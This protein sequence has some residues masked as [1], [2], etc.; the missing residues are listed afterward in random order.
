MRFN[1]FMWRVCI[2]VEHNGLVG[3]ADQGEL[4]E[5]VKRVDVEAVEAGEEDTQ[6]EKAGDETRQ[7]EGL[8]VADEL[9]L[10]HAERLD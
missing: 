5:K 8:L 3:D 4:P 6:L 7:Q 9:E 1:M 2:T 10:G